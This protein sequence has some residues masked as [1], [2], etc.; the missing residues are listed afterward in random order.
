MFEFFFFFS[1]SPLSFLFLSFLPLF[2]P[3]LLFPFL[4]LSPS[5]FLFLSFLN[6][7][8]LLPSFHF[9]FFFS[10]LS[11]YSDIIKQLREFGC[12]KGCFGDSLLLFSPLKQFLRR[13]DLVLVGALKRHLIY[14]EIL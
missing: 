3:F 6:F 12:N 11:I 10:L 13:G 2:F 9:F 4:Y 8:S 14:L 7:L 5:L 1:P